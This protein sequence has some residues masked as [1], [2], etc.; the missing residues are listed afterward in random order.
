M[1]K[2][3]YDYDADDADKIKELNDDDVITATHPDGLAHF[4]VFAKDFVYYPDANNAENLAEYSK[5]LMWETIQ[6]GTEWN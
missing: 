3:V 1:I 5:T 2:L 6:K 4:R